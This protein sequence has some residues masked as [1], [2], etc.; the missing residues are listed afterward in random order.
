[1]RLITGYH[2]NTVIFPKLVH[3][4]EIEHTSKRFSSGFKTSDGTRLGLGIVLPLAAAKM[5]PKK[6]ALPL[7]PSCLFLPHAAH[8]LSSHVLMMSW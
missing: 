8:F 3:L 6:G 4:V 1:M 2:R 7:A 5:D